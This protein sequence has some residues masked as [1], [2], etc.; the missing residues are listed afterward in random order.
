[1]AI[2]AAKDLGAYEKIERLLARA[3]TPAQKLQALVDGLQTL[4]VDARLKGAVAKLRYRAYRNAGAVGANGTG[5]IWEECDRDLNART[6]AIV[7]EGIPLATIRVHVARSS[8]ASSPCCL[9]FPE[10][11]A[12]WFAEGRAIIDSSCFC[13]EPELAQ[14][15]PALALAAV[16]IPVVLAQTFAPSW[17]VATPRRGHEGFYMRNFG[18][19]RLAKSRPYPGRDRPLALVG[20]RMELITEKIFRR[21]PAY[22]AGD[23]ELDAMRDL[24]VGAAR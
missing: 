21:Y 5:A 17:L 20:N 1:M 4:V 10:I 11:V 2:A 9:V 7:L 16:R 6:F 3:T 13:V 12:P 15:F 8:C 24:Y 18:G 23:A 22:R 14:R 19:K